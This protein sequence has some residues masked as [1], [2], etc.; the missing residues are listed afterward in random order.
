M[1]GKLSRIEMMKVVLTTAMIV[2]AVV[3]SAF[4]LMVLM[5]GTLIHIP[6]GFHI[7]A[8]LAH[9]D[10]QRLIWFLLSPLPDSLSFNHLSLSLYGRF[11][12]EQVK[13]IV[14]KVELLSLCAIAMA[15]V[16]EHQLKKNSRLLLNQLRVL[17]VTFVFML[18]GGCLF[19][20]D[21]DK[22]FI[23]LH[24][25]LFNNHWWILSPARDSTI[26]LM[27]LS[28]FLRCLLLWVV[29]SVIL[30]GIIYLL[31]RRQLFIS[32]FGLNKTNDS[33]N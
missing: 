10:Y 3:G 29:L 6:H 8:S 32:Y 23:W 9:G 11:H 22:H 24:H 5:S 27:P 7:S 2:I 33:R 21:F 19:A 26:L 15:C 30:G 31:I 17:E 25:L 18:V 14:M 20:I 1:N 13:A 12:Y 28:F 4:L 16:C